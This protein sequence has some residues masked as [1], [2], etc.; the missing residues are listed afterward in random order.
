MRKLQDA[1]MWLPRG[2]ITTT[3]NWKGSL[4]PVLSCRVKQAESLEHP[5]AQPEL[6]LSV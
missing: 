4:Y 1:A 2:S 5:D 3:K 6:Q